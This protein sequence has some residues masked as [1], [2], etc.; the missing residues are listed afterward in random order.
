MADK[1]HLPIFGV[2]PILCFP[3]GIL[4]AVGI[5]GSVKGV[6]PGQ[7]ENR[8]AQIVMLILGILLIVMGFVCYF[9]ADY[10]GGLIKSIKSN[11]LKT[12]GSYSFVRNPCYA[13]FLLG[14]V[15]VILIAHNLLLLILPLLHW[16]LLTIVLINTEEK[17]L[18]ELYGQEYADY[19]KRVNRCWP[20]FPKK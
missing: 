20:W 13:L 18:L 8:V 10:K 19:C 12:N 14:Y 11:H 17:W 16:G 4:V 7:V 1:K 6:I 2:G 15:G 9:G 3:M 5:F